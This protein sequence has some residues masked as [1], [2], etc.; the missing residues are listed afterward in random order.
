MEVLYEEI[1]PAVAKFV[2]SRKGSFEDAKDIFHDALIIYQENVVDNKLVIQISAKAYVVGIAKHL[3]IRKVTSDRQRVFF[4][5]YEKQ[6]EVGDDFVTNVDS[7][8]L[9]EALKLTGH[10]CLELLRSFYYEKISAGKIAQLFGYRTVH[11][12]TVQKYKCLEKIREEIKQKSLTY[13]DFFE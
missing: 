1:F 11:S 13:E 12:A 7:V 6:L 10:R 3:W 9:V 2:S 4:D 5:D 8:K